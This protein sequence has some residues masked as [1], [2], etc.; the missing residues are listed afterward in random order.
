MT[1]Q[2]QPL[3]WSLHCVVTGGRL[4]MPVEGLAQSD[5]EE[6]ESSSLLLCIV[7]LTLPCLF[8][9]RQ[10]LLLVWG[11]RKLSEVLWKWR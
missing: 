7:R 3:E 1:E 6:Q 11:T 8:F 10:I 9:S 4:P 2:D 5:E